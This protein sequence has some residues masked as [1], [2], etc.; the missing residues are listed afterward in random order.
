MSSKLAL[1]SHCEQSLQVL[2]IEKVGRVDH[3]VPR[4]HEP[5][6]LVGLVADRRPQREELWRQGRELRRGDVLLII[7][8]GRFVAPGLE[9]GER[10]TYRPRAAKPLADR[11]SQPLHITQ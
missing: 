4:F 1:A 3:P 10:V 11:L 8:G 7:S 6:R 9:V 2:R 5:S